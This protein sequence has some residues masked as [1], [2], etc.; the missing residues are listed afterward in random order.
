MGTGGFLP[1]GKAAG[2]QRM[3]GAIPP[4]PKYAFMT[5]CLFKYRNNFT[6]YQWKMYSIML[7]KRKHVIDPRYFIEES[8]YF[9]FKVGIH[10][11]L[12]G[13]QMREMFS[14]N[15]YSSFRR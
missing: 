8:E 7:E 6:F 4:L 5:C 3:H 9:P 2:G 14:Y 1:G 11:T 13:Y 15:Q 12:F 10:E